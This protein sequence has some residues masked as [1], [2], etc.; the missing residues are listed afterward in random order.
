MF[1]WGPRGGGGGGERVWIFSGTTHL[2]F[3]KDLVSKSKQKHFDIDNIYRIYYIYYI[4]TNKIP[5]EAKT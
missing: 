4:N 5:G 2:R 3:D 1:G